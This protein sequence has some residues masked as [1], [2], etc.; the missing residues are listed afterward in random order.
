MKKVAICTE[1]KWD[2]ETYHN[3]PKFFV[4]LIY[5]KLQTDTKKYGRK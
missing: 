5:L 3:Q 2:W 1:M 4:D